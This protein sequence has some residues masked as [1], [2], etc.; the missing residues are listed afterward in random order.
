MDSRDYIYEKL[1]RVGLPPIF[2]YAYDHHPNFGSVVWVDQAKGR[3][4]FMIGEWRIAN[5]D[6]TV[7]LAYGFQCVAD[8][9]LKL[10]GAGHGT[11]LAIKS[12]DGS[13]RYYPWGSGGVG[14]DKFLMPNQALID[15]G[16]IKAK[17]KSQYFHYPD[18]K[19]FNP[20]PTNEV[21]P[22]ETLLAE[23][24]QR[25]LVIGTQNFTVIT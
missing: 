9:N 12:P 16:T 15:F 10:L 3:G 17:N 14:L 2:N 21:M 19:W 4:E 11:A 22:R 7:S 24:Q 6:F 20:Y 25:L 18:L 1:E 5:P 13:E 23:I 8:A